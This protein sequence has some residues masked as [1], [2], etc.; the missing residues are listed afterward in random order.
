M[1][2]NSDSGRVNRLSV[3]IKLNGS[4]VRDG[5]GACPVASWATDASQQGRAIHAR[6]VVGWARAGIRPNMA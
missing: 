1:G 6:K 2:M 5:G 3:R 4:G